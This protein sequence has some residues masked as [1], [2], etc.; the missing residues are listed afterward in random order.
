LVRK[1]ALRHELAGRI[2][3]FLSSNKNA[4][5]ND[6]KTRQHLEQIRCAAQGPWR[7]PGV[8][9]TQGGVR[10]VGA[11]YTDIT[12]GRANIGAITLEKLTPAGGSVPRFRAS[13]ELFTFPSTL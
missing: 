8:I 3:S 1:R 7:P 12:R 6:G 5:G 2:F 10:S 4:T 13:D 9:V 11:S